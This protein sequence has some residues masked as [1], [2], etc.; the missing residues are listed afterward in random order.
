MSRKEMSLF[1]SYSLSPCSE[2]VGAAMEK[3]TDMQ[4]EIGHEIEQWKTDLILEIARRKGFKREALEDA[5]QQLALVVLEFKYDV[6]HTSGATERTALTSLIENQLN[7]KMR[8]E[9]RRNRHNQKIRRV[10]GP[11]RFE[12]MTCNTQIEY[13]RRFELGVDVR[14]TVNRMTM[15][16]QSVCKALSIGTPCVKV[17]ADLGISRHALV[18][19]LNRVRKQL[20]NAGLESI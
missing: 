2:R 13:E 19:I 11:S 12:Q 1:C 20:I 5:C 14:A 3:G 6:S 4:R 8:S 15:Q 9:G 10:C 7:M 17:A 18:Q 16:E